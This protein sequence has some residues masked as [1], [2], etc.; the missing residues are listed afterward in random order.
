MV[1]RKI[2]QFQILMDHGSVTTSFKKDKKAYR[3]S[4]ND[5][6]LP[7]ANY[8]RFVSSWWTEQGSL[9]NKIREITNF[10]CVDNADVTT[11]S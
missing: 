10:H 7:V 6:K 11:R 3:Q 1:Y 9:A 4:S 8:Q 5:S 2:R